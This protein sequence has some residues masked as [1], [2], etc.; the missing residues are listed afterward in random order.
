[1]FVHSILHKKYVTSVIL[2]CSMTFLLLACGTTAQSTASISSIVATMKPGDYQQTLK[3]G[4]Q[5]RSYVIHLPPAISGTQP[6]P[7]VV[8]LHDAGG[9]AASI[10]R[11]TRMNTM[12][13]QE[14]FLAVYPNGIAHVSHTKQLTWNCC[15]PVEKKSTGIDDVGFIHLLIEH[16]QNTYTIDA[17][18][19]YATGMADGGAMA[20]RLAC[21]LST[22]FAAIAPVAANFVYTQCQPTQ[23]VSV[24]QFDGTADQTVQQLAYNAVTFWVQQNQCTP[25]ARRESSRNMIKAIYTNGQSGTEVVQYTIIGGTHVWSSSATTLIWDFFVRHP[26]L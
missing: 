23:A 10:A 19:I 13:D 15:G 14:G 11:T 16:L 21:D 17:K 3:V 8:I 9:N 18:R 6:L 26:K 12:A 4:D 24:A 5:S 22:T 20:Y 1:M 2:L 7:L 25:V